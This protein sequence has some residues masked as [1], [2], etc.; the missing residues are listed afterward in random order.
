MY[1]MMNG[2]KVHVPTDG[3]GQIDSDDVRRGA[4]VD[5]ERPLVLSKSDGTNVVINPGER[6]LAADGDSLMDMPLHKRGR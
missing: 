3:S 1:V 2:R 6:L 4:G 5:D